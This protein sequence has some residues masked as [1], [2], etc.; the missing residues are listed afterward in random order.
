MRQN[1]T[2]FP[3][4]ISND[5]NIARAWESF[6]E[7]GEVKSTHSVRKTIY[8]SWVK[9]RE[10]GIQPDKERAQTVIT[11]DQIEEKINNEDL[12]RAGI[13]VLD[14]L[15]DIL[16]D[17]HHVVVLA[18][19]KG[20]I[21]YSVGHSQIQEELERI[22]FMPGGGW[23][24]Q[25]TG[26][27]G[28]GTPLSLGRPEIVMGHEHYCQ[29]WQS[30]VC[31][32]APIHDSIG[33]NIL[34]SVDITGPVK[35]LNTEIM[36]LAM[37]VANSIQSNLSIMQFHRRE[38]LRELA[39][40]LIQKWPSDGVLILDE[41]GYVIEYNSKAVTDLSL[42]PPEFLN[43][44]LSQFIPALTETIQHSVNKKSQIELNIHMER[45]SGVLHPVNVHI[46]PIVKDDKCIGT[47]IV[48]VEATKRIKNKEMQE[49]VSNRPQ[50]KYTFENIKGNSEK[51]N[52]TIHMARA[53]AHDRMESNVMLIGETGT[54]KEL[55][56]HSIHSESVRADMP[57]IAINCAAIPHDLIESELFGY[58]S[59][60][61]TGANRN[62]HKGKFEA[63]HNGTL[64]LDEIN[65]MSLDMQAKFLRVLDS[66]EINRIGS[67]EPITVNVRIIAAAN[68]AI[69]TAVDDGSFRLD[70]FHRLNVFDISIPKLS[71]RGDDIFELA[72]EF[73]KKEC[74]AAGRT[75]LQLSAEVNNLMKNYH[76]PGNIRELNNVCVRW[77][78]TVTGDS[79]TVDDLPEKISQSNF[80]ETPIASNN[81]RSVSDELI[82]QTLKQN[83]NNVSKSARILGID[84]T[85]IYRRRRHW[86]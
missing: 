15:S 76:W 54:G 10:L 61:F 56:A 9:S 40:E 28:V 22:N 6:T 32:G 33:Q 67:A 14:G 13:S 73:L 23:S 18:D 81:L 49:P 60:A 17:S 68:E 43:K 4:D 63:A 1:N 51:L 27:N 72:N 65:S 19:S 24:E 42:N 46:E 3:S 47:A 62:G 80:I 5:A 16:I 8:Q 78:L 37:S 38:L 77:V 82:K 20:R 25:A 55:L 57:F 83:N 21:F 44:T 11:A 7:H 12:G 69:H 53:A 45:H 64:F 71:E 70:L 35:N 74:L 85:T 30:W 52:K 29:N 86:C 48:L 31:Y 79:I 39:K 84:R 41:N 50:S 36:A 66:M 58:V 59:G 26:P 75:T 34:G 2:N